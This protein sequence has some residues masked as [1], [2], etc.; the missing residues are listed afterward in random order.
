MGIEKQVIQVGATEP[1]PLHPACAIFRRWS[2]EEYRQATESLS[3]IGQMEP[4]EIYEGQVID[5][6][7]RQAAIWDAGRGSEIRWKDVTNELV[8]KSITPEQYALAK[9]INRRHLSK[10][11]RA[12]MVAR[13]LAKELPLKSDPGEPVKRQ[14]KRIKDKKPKKKVAE[15]VTKVAE[16]AKV[17]ESTAKLAVQVVASGNQDVIDAVE[18]GDVSLGAAREIL[19]TGGNPETKAM[20]LLKKAEHSLAVVVRSIAQAQDESPSEDYQACRSALNAAAKHLT[21]WADSLRSLHARIKSSAS[22][23]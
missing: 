1:F 11:E 15:V 5:G 18:R 14:P 21:H 19:V 6:A 9:N 2:D 3:D 10:S 23:G 16:E 8:M 12:V 13:L 20:G 17:S 22:G 7:N 4:I